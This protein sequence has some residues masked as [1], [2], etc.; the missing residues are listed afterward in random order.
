MNNFHIN[1]DILLIHPSKTMAYGQIDKFTSTTPDFLLG[2]VDSYIES[3]GYISKV[4]DLD[5]TKIS[6]IDLLSMISKL[7]QNY[8]E[9]FQLV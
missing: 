3:N 1:C 9:F 4:I 7:A 6:E 8:L 5:V 2:L